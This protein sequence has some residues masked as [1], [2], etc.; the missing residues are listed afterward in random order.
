LRK[1]CREPFMSST[2][3]SLM[4]YLR[5]PQSTECSWGWVGG[6][7][8]A[9]DVGECVG[10]HVGESVCVR[11]VRVCV[12]TFRVRVC[13]CGLLC[14]LWCASPRGGGGAIE[15]RDRHADRRRRGYRV[16]RA[17]LHVHGRAAGLPAGGAL[18]PRASA[19]SP[20]PPPHGT[21]RGAPHPTAAN[22]ATW[23]PPPSPSPPPRPPSHG[24]APAPG[25]PPPRGVCPAW[26][27]RKKMTARLLPSPPP[28]PLFP[29]ASA[30][31]LNPSMNPRAAPSP[32]GAPGCGV[33]RS[34]PRRACGTPRQRSC[35]R[36]R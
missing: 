21:P 20:P 24:P 10:V 3:G 1:V 14:A 27:A 33:C 22:P 16:R 9:G 19:A 4:G 35:S 26:R 8:E 29:P 30:P 34:N 23:S 18:R 13:A 5:D 31:Q 12:G 7:G 17:Q 32:P 28:L 25:P 6:W 36:R 11:C 15:G 2:N